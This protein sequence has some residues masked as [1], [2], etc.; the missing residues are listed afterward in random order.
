ME[1]AFRLHISRSHAYFL[2]QRGFIPSI[3]I[4]KSRRVQVQ[5][6]QDYISR[7]RDSSN[8]Y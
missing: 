6:L 2:M 5:D 7:N 3:H 8:N 1:V 4:G